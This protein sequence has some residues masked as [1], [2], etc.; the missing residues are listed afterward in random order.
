MR[1]RHVGT[2]FARLPAGLVGFVLRARRFAAPPPIDAPVASSPL[3]AGGGV[4]IAS[5]RGISRC[6]ASSCPPSDGCPPGRHVTGPSGRSDGHD[7]EASSHGN[8]DGGG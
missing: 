4:A 1:L 2:T 3:G 8:R 5:R 7:E 6:L